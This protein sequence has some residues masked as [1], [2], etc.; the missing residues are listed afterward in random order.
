MEY[1]LTRLKDV[2]G[3]INYKL[4]KVNPCL[5]ILITFDHEQLLKE[6]SLLNIGESKIIQIE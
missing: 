2:E 4:E 1:K 6:A 5:F 3:K